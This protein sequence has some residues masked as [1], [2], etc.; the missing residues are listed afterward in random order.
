[1][2]RSPHDLAVVMRFK[3][4]ARTLPGVLAALRRQ[5]L[6]PD[7]LLG[8]DTG[9]RDGSPELIRQAGG[10]VVE[11]KQAYQ[12]A[13]VLNF[14]IQHSPARLVMALSSHTVVEGVDTLERMVSKFADPTVA[15][16]SGDWDPQA[17]PEERLDRA[18]L[19][20][21][22]L[23]FGS[24]YSNSFGMFR[25]AFWEEETFTDR[26]IGMED[27]AWALNQI[28]RSRVVW[29]LRFP[30]QYQRS[31]A[32]RDYSYACIAFRLADQHR[33]RLVWLGWRGSLQGWWRARNRSCADEPARVRRAA[34]MALHQ[35]RLKAWLLWRWVNPRTET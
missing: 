30:F 24:I 12:H 33:L 1:M 32:T 27:Y 26:I 3:D 20:R 31:G 23:R 21:N 5:S 6:Q 19:E 25:R 4:S 7:L 10:E 16:V 28:D 14:G 8:V 13:R 17:P 35:D 18:T 29:R 15:A 34:E 2:S 11:W 9:S 22:G